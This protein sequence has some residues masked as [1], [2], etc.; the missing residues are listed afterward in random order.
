MLKK[1]RVELSKIPKK[2]QIV[3]L[4]QEMAHRKKRALC[5]LRRT[6]TDCAYGASKEARRRT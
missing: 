6:G 1:M 2:E 5:I 4:E 3:L